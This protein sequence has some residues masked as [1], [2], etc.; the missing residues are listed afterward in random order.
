MPQ[1]EKQTIVTQAVA[2][3]GFGEHLNAGSIVAVDVNDGPSGG[4]GGRNVPA[5]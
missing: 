1:I 3:R 4:G 2:E 5:F